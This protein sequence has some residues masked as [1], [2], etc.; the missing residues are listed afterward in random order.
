[1]AIRVDTGGRGLVWSRLRFANWSMLLS[2]MT[3]PSF[4]PGFDSAADVRLFS[5]RFYWAISEEASATA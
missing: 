1:M 2:E 3:R 4:G 5:W